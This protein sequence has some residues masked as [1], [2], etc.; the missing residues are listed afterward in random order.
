MPLYLSEIV[1]YKYR[2]ALNIGFQLFIMV[3]ILVANVLN[4]FFAKIK[5]GWGWRLSLG[6]A[7]VPTLIVTVGSLVLSNTPNSM[8]K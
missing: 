3:G 5:G 2:G 6:G 7:V 1:L 4:F 8:I